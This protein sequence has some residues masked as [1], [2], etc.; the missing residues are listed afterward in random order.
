MIPNSQ[1]SEIDRLM[2]APLGA[3]SD[4]EAIDCVA[5]LIDLSNEAGS[6]DGVTRSFSQLNK[7]GKRNLS[8]A[9]Q[10]LLHY[11]R[12]NAWA[13]KRRLDATTGPRLRTH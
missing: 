3:M 1:S 8:P 11:F 9:D 13:V 5:T 12:A 7:V 4:A 2:K 6:K 10:A